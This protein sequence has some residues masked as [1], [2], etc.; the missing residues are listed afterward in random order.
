MNEITPWVTA[1]AS[2]G[3]GLQAAIDDLVSARIAARQSEWSA[4]HAKVRRLRQDARD[5]LADSFALRARELQH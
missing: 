5:D 1:F 2:A 4:Y 3:L